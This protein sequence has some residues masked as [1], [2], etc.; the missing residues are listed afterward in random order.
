M[1]KRQLKL[2]NVHTTRNIARKTICIAKTQ[3]KVFEERVF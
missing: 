3:K 1:C 2:D